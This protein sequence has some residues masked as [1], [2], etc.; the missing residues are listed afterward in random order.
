M[1]YN[2]TDMFW[3]GRV[4]AIGMSEQSAITGVGTGGYVMWFAFGLI[5]IAKIGTERQGRA[6]DSAR[7]ITRASNVMRRTAS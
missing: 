4:D 3:I 5:L 2:L 6:C 1:A 7:T